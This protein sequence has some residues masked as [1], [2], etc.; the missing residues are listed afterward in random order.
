MPR[1]PCRRRPTKP[2]N[3]HHPARHVSNRGRL[4]L[5]SDFYW[6][7]RPGGAKYGPP[8]RTSVATQTAVHS[9][10]DSPYP[11]RN[12]EDTPPLGRQQRTCNVALWPFKPCK[13]LRARSLFAQ[14]TQHF[15]QAPKARLWPIPGHLG[16]PVQRCTLRWP[17][18]S[19]DP[20][21]PA[22]RTISRKI[23]SRTSRIARSER[24]LHSI[25]RIV[26]WLRKIRT[27]FDDFVE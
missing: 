8:I 16:C 7:H 14:N 22:V 24:L 4:V 20:Q 6:S 3:V 23:P 15:F 11:R 12:F 18:P 13:R 19:E 10:R 21:R 27:I 25:C 1:L 9:R 26:S 17:D 2:S 5:N